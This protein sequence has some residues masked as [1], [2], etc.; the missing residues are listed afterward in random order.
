MT[1]SRIRV[2]DVCN[3]LTGG[4]RVQVVDIA[5]ESVATHRE[6][7]DYDVA[8]YKA[9]ALLDVADDERVFTCVY[10]SG[11]A[12]TT[13]SGTYDLPSSRLA[14][15]PTENANQDLDRVQET[16]R[17]RFAEAMVAAAWESDADADMVARA[18]DAI[19]RVDS[20]L[21]ETADELVR[22]DRLAKFGGDDA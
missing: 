6:Q 3:D 10:L 2:G 9:N 4:G 1:D 7:N 13:F 18:T 21:A 12:T 19:A 5:A 17:L 14:R 20:E 16:I 22:A 11:D 15:Q 8:T